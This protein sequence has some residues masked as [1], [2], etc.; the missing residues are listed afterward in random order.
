VRNVNNFNFCIHFDLELKEEEKEMFDDFL[1][2]VP[3]LE[4]ICPGIVFGSVDVVCAYCGAVETHDARDDG[5][6]EYCCGYC[7][8]W[9]EV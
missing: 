8:N 4:A 1:N 9:T 5:S 7:G 6:N 2:D 3:E